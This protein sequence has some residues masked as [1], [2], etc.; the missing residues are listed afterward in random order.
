MAFVDRSFSS[1]PADSRVVR[2]LF[3]LADG[4]LFGGVLYV[5]VAGV[6]ILGETDI[7][8]WY[9]GDEFWGVAFLVL[10]LLAI[11]VR[12]AVLAWLASRDAPRS[13]VYDEWRET[14]QW[15]WVGVVAVTVAGILLG[16]SVLWWGPRWYQ[17]PTLL[18]ITTLLVG[19]TIRLTLHYVIESNA[20]NA[21]PEP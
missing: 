19:F 15:R 21:E 17:D 8:G 16:V 2:L 10:V 7:A 9:P 4:M 18:V 20:E 6:F 14:V 11:A 3:Y 12:N 13:R 1:G 5:V